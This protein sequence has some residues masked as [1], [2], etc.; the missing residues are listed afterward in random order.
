MRFAVEMLRHKGL[1]WH[2][3][4]FGEEVG[5]WRSHDKKQAKSAHNKGAVGRLMAIGPWGNRTSILTAKGT[6]LQDPELVHG[7]QPK[8]VAVE[9]LRLSQPRIMPEG[10]SK[11]A[12]KDLSSRWQTIKTPEGKELW[13]RM[14]TGQTHYSSPFL[15]EVKSEAADLAEEP[16]AYWGEAT[17]PGNAIVCPEVVE[18]QPPDDQPVQVRDS[19]TKTVPKAR[20]I[21]NKVVMNTSGAQ[22][23]RWNQAT[24]KELQ[25]FLKIDW[26]EPTPELRAR[27]FAAKKKVVMQVLVFS[28]KPMTAEKKAQGLLGDEYEKARICLQTRR[29]PSPELHDQC[30]RTPS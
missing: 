14:D 23:E 5:M 22:Y 16:I 10:W 26:K 11:E 20:I 28:L 19:L 12:V 21:P 18:F 27:Y 25:A 24:S 15:I 17:E 7:L 4:A 13:L 6:D 29:L 30:R 3:P 1:G 8:I 9:C 2:V